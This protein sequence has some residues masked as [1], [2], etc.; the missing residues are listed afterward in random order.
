[1]ISPWNNDN[2]LSDFPIL[3]TLNAFTLHWLDPLEHCWIEA[4]I[5]ANFSYSWSEKDSLKHVTI[6]YLCRYP[7]WKMKKFSSTSGLLVWGF[8]C[9]FILCFRSCIWDHYCFIL[10][11]TYR[12]SLMSLSSLFSIKQLTLKNAFILLGWKRKSD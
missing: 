4:V 2:F 11:I 7:L 3:T 5:K 1:M 8:V 6:K 12:F 10:S 9:C